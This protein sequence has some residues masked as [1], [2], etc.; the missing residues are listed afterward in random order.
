MTDSQGWAHVAPDTRLLQAGEG[1]YGGVNSGWLSGRCLLEPGCCQLSVLVLCSW[2]S[3]TSYRLLE[4]AWPDV[5]WLIQTGRAHRTGEFG[6]SLI[7]AVHSHI[8]N[9]QDLH[10]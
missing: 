5:A 2:D 1:R 10:P 4:G 9:A 7:C 3:N 8:R 6:S